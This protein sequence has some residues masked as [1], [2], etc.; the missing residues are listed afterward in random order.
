MQQDQ[1]IKGFTLLELI[2]VIVIVGII[3]AVGYPNFTNWKDEREARFSAE[4]IA[5]MLSNLGTQVNRGSLLYSQLY[6]N[7]KEDKQTKE[8]F[9]VFFTKGMRSSTYS[10]IL[11][12]G[13]TP[14]CKMTSQG[15]WDEIK[16][17]DPIDINGI[18]YKQYI[19]SFDPKTNDSIKI[20]LQFENESAVCFGKSG[21]YYKTNGDLPLK[22][23]NRNLKIEDD[24]TSNYIILCLKKTLDKYGL[25]KTCPRGNTLKEPAYLIKWSRFANIV[26]YR[27]N[28]DNKTWNR[29]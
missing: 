2:V 10:A 24:S 23:G 5:S 25:G 3:S 4:K 27:W 21:N 12:S 29:Q 18:D 11:N 1:G 19:E 22:S 7:W 13:N 15:T 14:D 16:D 9:P 17:V 26:K 28:D 6:I 8:N 20:A